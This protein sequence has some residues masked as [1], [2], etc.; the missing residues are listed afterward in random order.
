MKGLDLA[1]YVVNFMCKRNTPVSNLQL[2]KILYYINGRYYQR[3]NTFLIEDKFLAYPYGPV[4]R[5]VYNEFKRY[6]SSSI[7]EEHDTPLCPEAQPHEQTV[8][9]DIVHYSEISIF[10]LVKASHRPGTAWYETEQN[11]GLFKEIGENDI[12]REFNNA[13]L[14]I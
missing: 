5:N 10:E 2:Q 1:K 13:E 3:Y 12:E 6:G 4:L 11:F 7:I 8:Q 14:N 9:E